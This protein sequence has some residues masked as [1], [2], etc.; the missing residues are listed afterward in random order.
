MGVLKDDALTQ[1]ALQSTFIKL[2]QKGDTVQNQAAMKSWLFRVAYNEAMLVRRKQTT[3]NKH[4]EKFARQ[5]DWSHR[6]TNDPDARM[7]QQEMQAKVKD[8]LKQLSPEQY[9]VV[10]KRI[11]QG[12]KFREIADALDVPLGTVL[13]RMHGSLK[14]LRLVLAHLQNND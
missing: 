8:A 10:E 4:V 14:R 11:Y 12:L 3:A 1:D 9:D 2:M 6:Q 7:I 13:A 5:V